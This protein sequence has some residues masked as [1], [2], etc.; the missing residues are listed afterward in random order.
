[1]CEITA[2]SVTGGREEKVMEEVAVI[3]VED[4]QVVMTDIL[5]REQTVQGSI[6]EIRLLEHK[7]FL[8]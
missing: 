5:G 1:M 6:R 3:R 2:Y 4:G 7:V 8:T